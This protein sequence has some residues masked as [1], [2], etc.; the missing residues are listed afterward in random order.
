MVTGDCLKTNAH[1]LDVRA[2]TFVRD[3]LPNCF[4]PSTS[5]FVAVYSGMQ[6]L[7]PRDRLKKIEL[8]H[9]APLLPDPKSPG[10]QPES[11]SEGGG[12]QNKEILLQL[13][14]FRAVEPTD[15]IGGGSKMKF[16][17]GRFDFNCGDFLFDTTHRHNGKPIVTDISGKT[18][19]AHFRR[20]QSLE[21][22]WDLPIQTEVF[23]VN[24]EMFRE[25]ENM[26]PGTSAAKSLNGWPLP[27]VR[28][29]RAYSAEE[30]RG[31]TEFFLGEIV[32][33]VGQIEKEVYIILDFESNLGTVRQQDLELLGSEGAVGQVTFPF[34]IHLTEP[35][36][37][38]E[39]GAASAG[40]AEVVEEGVAA[41]ETEIIEEPEAVEEPEEVEEPELR[42]PSKSSE[43]SDHSWEP[44]PSEMTASPVSQETSEPSSEPEPSENP[45]SPEPQ[46]AVENVK[47]SKENG[48]KRP[49][50]DDT[51]TVPPAKKCKTKE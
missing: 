3:A 32:R 4:V 20:L 16:S 47:N 34:G 15:K 36:L 51:P 19:V 23:Q 17:V 41:L 29:N 11:E 13:K 22:P 30:A 28:L 43:G 14:F 1:E 26:V 44:E 39:L 49:R 45:G 6:G 27:L 5:R 9:A 7:V 40:E 8:H 48:T 21:T 2:G 37:A 46:E 50:N 31:G 42:S 24:E 18:G 35:L 38:P 25:G 33:M 10:Q 12:K